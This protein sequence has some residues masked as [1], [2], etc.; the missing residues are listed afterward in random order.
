MS[1]LTVSQYLLL[2]AYSIF[3][4]DLFSSYILSTLLQRIQ[5]ASNIESAPGNRF[6]FGDFFIHTSYHFPLVFHDDG[7]KLL[8]TTA[9][10]F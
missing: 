1:R 8:Y 3:A 6:T 2:S 5:S 4:T 7:I 9:N 10:F